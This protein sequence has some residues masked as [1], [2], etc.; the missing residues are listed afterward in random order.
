MKTKMNLNMKIVVA[1]AGLALFAGACS[2]NVADLSDDELRE[3]LV[4]VLSEGDALEADTAACVVDE[5]F[6]NTDRDQL[7]QIAEAEDV[8]DLTQGDQDIV[9][10]A[11]ITCIQAGS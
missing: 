6:E 11:V 10:D 7:N 9:T 2:T 5:L 8:T 4:E 1:I 3:T